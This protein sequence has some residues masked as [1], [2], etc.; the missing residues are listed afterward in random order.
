MNRRWGSAVAGLT[1]ALAGCGGGEL[2]IRS[3]VLTPPPSSP[4]A[5]FYVEKPEV[6]SRETGDAVWQQNA[7][8]ARLLAD[9]LKSALR[10]K[11]KTLTPPPTDLVR[12][13]I[14]LAY[15]DVPIKGK[16]GQGAKAHIEVRL[17]L[18]DAGGVVRYSTHTQAPI[19]ESRTPAWLGGNPVTADEI[20]RATLERAAQDFV[21]RL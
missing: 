21:S 2:N 8:Y 3:Q 6:Q 4:R 19:Q 5:E 15:T 17:Q 7:E 20:I 14:Y 11:G 9:K 13:R 10:D 12:S 1:M 18:V 16:P